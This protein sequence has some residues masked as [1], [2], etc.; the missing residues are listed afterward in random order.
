LADGDLEVA[1]LTS[2]IV[3]IDDAPRAFEVLRAA[4]TMKVLVAPNG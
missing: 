1:D 3:P 2:A 4:G